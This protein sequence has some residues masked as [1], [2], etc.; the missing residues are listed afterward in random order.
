MNDEAP[1][2][3][4]SHCHASEYTGV[5]R[6]ISPAGRAGLIGVIMESRG[7]RLSTNVTVRFFT[8]PATMG[9]GLVTNVSP[10]G[11]FL[12]TRA[13]LRLL[14]MVYL[15]PADSSLSESA[16]GRIATVVR[17]SAT[18]FGLKWCEFAAQTTKVYA[19]LAAGSNDLAD[20]HQLPLPAIPISLSSPGCADAGQ[21]GANQRCPSTPAW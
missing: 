20:A 1:S 9:M 12:E 15:E 6:D 3:E 2:A 21:G 13:S 18:G 7:Q 17:H 11:A 5:A 16:R 19:R 14:S 10:T 4:Q 8:R